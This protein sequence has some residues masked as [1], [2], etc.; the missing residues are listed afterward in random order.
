M[1][2]LHL[3]SGNETGGGMFHILSL[4]EYLQ[5]KEQVIL[6][7][8]CEGEL[9]ERAKQK[10]IEVVI[11]KQKYRFDISVINEIL[12]YIQKN[13]IDIIHSHG[14]RAN[15][16]CY[17]SKRHLNIPWYITVHSSPLDDFLN[18]GLKGK[19]FTQINVKAILAADR[20]LAISER[21]KRDLINLGVQE[22]KIV[23]ILNGI[24]FNA[25]PLVTY[26]RQ[27]FGFKETDFLIM[28]VA[29]LEPVK[30]HETALMALKKLKN[31][32]NSLKLVL[33]GDGSRKKEIQQMTIDFGLSNNVIFLGHR[34]DVPALLEIADITLLTSKSESFPLV[35]LES[36]RAK[37]P[38]I[39]TD[40]G[41][42]RMLIPN[43]EFG[44]IVKVGDV[45]Q[46]VKEIWELYKLKE[47]GRLVSMGEK[48]YE[49]AKARFSIEAFGE[50]VR[51]A[52]RLN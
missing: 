25:S 51:K 50:S 39:T 12:K 10:G 18:I 26:V 27:Q 47:A 31:K 41:D 20:I 30:L 32:S 17:L 24:D 4:L 48:L 9:A 49:H 33:V 5:H 28:M 35:L 37:K 6:G 16:I 7:V 13:H 44:R 11:F 42:V 40:V 19:L 1:K 15:A 36:A 14:A 8:F 22:Q 34:N 38:I 23:T 46:L 52:Y 2:I 21:F 29:R 3:N 45:N 43:K